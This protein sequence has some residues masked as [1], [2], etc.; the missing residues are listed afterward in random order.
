MYTIFPQGLS[1]LDNIAYRTHHE[2]KDHK[3]KIL[4][5]IPKWYWSQTIAA[6]DFYYLTFNF[7]KSTTKPKGLTSKRFIQSKDNDREEIDHY[8]S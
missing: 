6:K 1:I 3:P 8:D 4:S 5:R 7:H 2:R